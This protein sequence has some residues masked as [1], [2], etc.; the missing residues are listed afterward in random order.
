[1]R[2]SAN[3]PRDW[4][5]LAGRLGGAARGFTQDSL[6][7]V[8]PV[9]APVAQ[10]EVLCEDFAFNIWC[11]FLASLAIE[12]LGV[13][14]E[15]QW[16]WV[17]H[18][19]RIPPASFVR[20]VLFN[21]SPSSRDAGSRRARTGP[22]NSGHRLLLRWLGHNGIDPSFASDRQAWNHLGNR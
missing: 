21:L 9:L 8:L 13:L 6:Q 12:R 7:F 10:H 15:Q 14:L 22:N 2:M 18:V 5:R 11:N 20:N 4:R 16:K 17:G 19:L 3:A 1:M